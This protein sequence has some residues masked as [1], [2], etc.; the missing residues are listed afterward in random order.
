[1]DTLREPAQLAEL[2]GAIC[3][4]PITLHVASSAGP[5]LF[6][7][8]GFN[9]HIHHNELFQTFP[10]SN[11]KNTLPGIPRKRNGMHN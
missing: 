4:P 5:W 9:F 2:Q 11:L 7:G 3:V 10:M 1:M 6:L 8:R